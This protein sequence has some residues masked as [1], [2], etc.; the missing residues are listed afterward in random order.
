[1]N[2]DKTDGTLFAFRIC[3]LQSGIDDFIKGEIHDSQQHDTD[4]LCCTQHT[5]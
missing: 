3:L 2:R 5:K 1:M 4:K